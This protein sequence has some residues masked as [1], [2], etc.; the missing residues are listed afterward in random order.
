MREDHGAPDARDQPAP[1]S[2][3]FRLWTGLS[4]I[5]ACTIS[6]GALAVVLPL[7]DNVPK[8]DQWSLLEVWEAH[9]QGRPV[10]PLLL[11]PYNGHLNVLPRFL[12]YGLG[13]ITHWNVRIEV[14]LSLLL[15]ICT[16]AT[17]LLMLRDS[18]EELLLFAAPLSA[19]VFSLSQ[20][21]NFL[22]GY[23]LGQ[24]LSQLATT[25]TLFSLT[26]PRITARHVAAGAAA[27]AVATFSWG[28]G[29]VAWPIGLMALLTR[30][31]HHRKALI[32]WC[33]LLLVCVL[34][35]KRG[36][37]GAGQLGFQALLEFD[38]AFF[39]ALIGR[40]INYRAFPDFSAAL[41]IGFLLVLAFALTLEGALRS[42]RG[43]LGLR[44]GLLGVSTLG[45]AGLITLARAKTGQGQALASHYA[46][47]VYPL[48][49]SV[50][51]LGCQALLAWRAGVT[52][53]FRRA[54]ATLLLAALVSLPVAMVL[55]QSSEMLPILQSWVQ[56]SRI[57]DRKLL[58]GTITDDEIRRSLH[59]DPQLV[60]RGVVL[61]REHR[62][63]AWADDPPAQH[64]HGD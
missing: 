8:W 10:L 31:R 13:L 7:V 47:A 33:S 18:G 19:L 40:P 14:V 63:A 1:P 59:P 58:A 25:L 37:G 54:A 46:T 50:L 48:A 30:L 22:S 42:R 51:V 55:V 56:L 61:L 26:R 3:A 53:R 35:V 12:F 36:A 57:H 23:P 29:L 4:L 41:G 52:S 64:R 11:K 21:E 44:W 38:T 60:R 2:R 9:F 6:V 24:V 62:L 27:A 15:T 45:S 39:L 32:L 20:Y 5:V 43:L 17:L 34:T 16:A 28:A 49:L